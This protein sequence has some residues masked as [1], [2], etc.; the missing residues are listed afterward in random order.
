[1][2]ILIIF[3]I[4]VFTFFHR[5][6][7]T[8]SQ[9]TAE[10][11]LKKTPLTSNLYYSSILEPKK[12]WV[13]S[14]PTDG[15]IDKLHFHFGDRVNSGKVLFTISSSKFQTDYKTTLMQYIKAKTEYGNSQSQLKESEFLHNNQLISD[16]DFKAKQLNFYNARLSLL[17]AKDSL[18]EMQKQISL[19]K[20]HLNELKIE[21]IDK[22]SSVLNAQNTLRQIRIMS[23]AEG[24]ILLPTKDESNGELKKISKGDAV[25]QGDVIGVIGDVT[26]L[27]LHIYVSEFNINQIKPDQKVKVSILAFPD[28][29]LEG[30]IGAINRQAES[31]QG[32][33]PVFPVEIIVPTLSA[34]EQTKIHIGMS[35]KVTIEIQNGNKIVVPIEA[36]T[37]KNGKPFLNIKDKKT[38]KIKLV[39]VET[40]ETTM[41]S[42]VIDSNALIGETLVYNR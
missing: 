25:K 27:A 22:I 26:G 7:K 10:F 1:M 17:Q 34:T 35:A 39:S 38:G 32:G 36:V 21:D 2:C 19:D 5:S 42:V 20:I 37:Q 29:E 18:N 41:D 11:V 12:T 23:N 28:I 8:S 33:L 16:D 4:I 13:I 31:I 6:N 3:L 15:V 30:K 9:N 24:V 40:G 14:S